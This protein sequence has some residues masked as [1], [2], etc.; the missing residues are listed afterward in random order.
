MKIGCV[1]YLNA[2]PL[3]DG[4]PDS[5]DFDVPSTLC[6][7]LARGDLDVALVSSIEYLRRPHYRIVDGVSISA[8]GPVYSVIVA[9]REEL[10]RITQ[11]EVDPASATSIALVRCL[12]AARQLNVRLSQKQG[13]AQMLIGDQAI[14]FRQTHPGYR[15]WDLAEEWTNITG[16]SF[17]FALWLVR[18]EVPNA[19]KIADRLRTLRDENLRCLD[20]LISAGNSL[21]AEFCGRYFRENLCFDFGE[22][23]KAGLCEFHRHCVACGIDVTQEIELDLV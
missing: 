7:K 23:E 9:H 18:P 13:D 11:I 22:R 8:F 19:S 14:R 5:V 4:W 3:I 20:E 21:D 16:L 1:K 2:R 6:R 17:V 15:F 10:S 12:L